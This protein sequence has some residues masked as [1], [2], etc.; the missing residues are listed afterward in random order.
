[1]GLKGLGG[2]SPRETETSTTSKEEIVPGHTKEG[3][4][5]QDP[6]PKNTLGSEG[7]SR[8]MKPISDIQRVD[9]VAREW[10]RGQHADTCPL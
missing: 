2:K 9:N 5:L 8:P 1:V 4:G 10:K 3:R 7:E 6:K